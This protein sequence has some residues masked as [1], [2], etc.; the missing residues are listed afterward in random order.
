MVEGCVGSGFVVA[1]FGGNCKGDFGNFEQ[2]ASKSMKLR[3]MPNVV[4]IPTIP[5]LR[6]IMYNLSSLFFI[7]VF[8][9]GA[10]PDFLPPATPPAKAPVSPAVPPKYRG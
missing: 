2:A 3:A 6:A 10:L 8:L 9:F 7:F 5:C 1:V 4:A